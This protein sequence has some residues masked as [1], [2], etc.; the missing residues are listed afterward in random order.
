MLERLDATVVTMMEHILPVGYELLDSGAGEKLERF[1]SKI[2]RRPSSLCLWQ[3]HK[4]ELWETVHAQYDPDNGWRCP[5]GEFS[6]WLI[7]QNDIKLKL[8]LQRNGQIGFFP[9][10]LTTLHCLDELLDRT[11]CTRPRILNLFAFTGLAS[12][13][14]VRRGGTVCHVDISKQALDWANQNFDLNQLDRTKIRVISDDALTFVSREVKRQHEYDI[15]IA[16]PPSFSRV[17]KGKS[18]D[19]DQVAVDFIG[20]CLKLLPASGGALFFSSHH[21]ALVPE[22]VSNIIS[23]TRGEESAAVEGVHFMLI[24]SGTGRNLPAGTLTVFTVGNF[25]P[26]G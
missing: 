18:W 21:P 7:S 23:D 19:L 10:H 22:V 12:I 2:I 3:R 17:A 15:I 8:Q 11:K 25:S 13:H 14:G 9:E 24:E 1:G 26:N 16:D 4:P 6:N 5:Q 20:N